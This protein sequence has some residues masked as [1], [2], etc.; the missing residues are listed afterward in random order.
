[1]KKQIEKF[2][3]HNL[4]PYKESLKEEKRGGHDTPKVL[5]VGLA[6]LGDLKR[7]RGRESGRP[8]GFFGYLA[9]G[10]ARLG[11]KKVRPRKEMRWSYGQERGRRGLHCQGR[12]GEVEREGG[13]DAWLWFL[14]RG[15][16]LGFL[17][18]RA[19]HSQ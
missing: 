1:M 17:Q 14:T 10:V 9:S 13:E 3:H 2:V 6:R 4:I 7:G 11:R 5:V 18:V 16:R 15:S 8:A 12:R 19:S